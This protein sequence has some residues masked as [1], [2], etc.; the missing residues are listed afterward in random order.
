M[1][2]EEFR[3]KGSWKGDIEKVYSWPSFSSIVLPGDC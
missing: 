2:L 3:D 1:Y